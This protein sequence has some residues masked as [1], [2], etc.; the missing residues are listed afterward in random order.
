V[1]L[2][3]SMQKETYTK[4]SADRTWMKLIEKKINVKNKMVAD[5]GVGGGIYSIALAELGAK[6]VIGID[7]SENMINGAKENC[8][9][10]PN[11][12]FQLGTSDA[13][14]LAE[15]EVE[16]VLER[17]LIH[18]LNQEQLKTCIKEAKRIL[19]EGGTY[20]IQD[21][22]V[23]DC[24]LEGSLEH[25]RGYFFEI[26]PKL[27]EKD[28]SRRHSIETVNQYLEEVGFDVVQTVSFWENRKVYFSSNELREE[29]IS[30]KG[31]SL[32]FELNDSEIQTL[33]NEVIKK[34]VNQFPI[35]EKERW[36][37]WFAKK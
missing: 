14:G 13:T 18:H 5:V 26:Y 12:T 20:I 29:I 11:I 3:D 4:R 24:I 1:E 34:G 32:L 31:R 25:I 28:I 19:T 23:E 33:A 6:A 22:T 30:R 16:V 17:A 15:N 7:I 35:Y 2:F 37:I 10:Y 9:D 8:K 36:T 27:K 21:R